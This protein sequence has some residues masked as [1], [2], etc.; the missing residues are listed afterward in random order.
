MSTAGAAL[1]PP[2]PRPPKPVVVPFLVT[3]VLFSLVAVL[4]LAP[5]TRLLRRLHRLCVRPVA[6]VLGR[7]P[8]PAA[9]DAPS[10]LAISI[11]S[12]SA[13]AHD[14]QLAL[15]R[16]RVAYERMSARHRRVGD[17]LAWHR[18]LDRAEDAVELNAHVTDEL[19]AIGLELA[20]QQGEP[21]GF[22]TR[23]HKESARVVE[24]LKHFVRD[25]SD[26]GKAE[27]DALFPPIL[28]A[29][30]HEFAPSATDATKRRRVLVPGCGLGR[31]AYEIAAEGFTTIGNDFSHFMTLGTALVFSR[32][33]S[34]HQHRVSPY[35]HSFSHHRTAED[36]VRTVA[37]PDVVPSRAVDLAFEQGDFL[38]LFPP[39]HDATFD[40]VVTLFFIDTASN[41]LDY[42]ETISRLLRPGGIWI[43]EGPLL[44]YGNPGMEL[45]LEDVIKAAEL[46]GFEIE[47]RQ[48]LKEVRYTADDKG[49]YTF[50]YDC[51]F[52]IARKPAAAA[53]TTTTTTTA[54]QT[55]AGRTKTA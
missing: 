12:Y 13:Y 38:T 16:K 54:S 14:Q 10:N 40:A 6:V 2:P 22:R 31:L 37:F 43:N 55:A 50:A 1:P 18:T 36:L 7:I 24:T 30:R 17:H 3:L 29:L 49:M 5:P 41:L 46:V 25:W 42:F 34:R 26:E 20:R 33:H 21:Y 11:R 9:F 23:L 32:T 48:T 39:D 53:M 4:T 8:L 44:Y 51:E 28:D 15:D 19:A 52:W 27:R 35:V 47:R 45:P